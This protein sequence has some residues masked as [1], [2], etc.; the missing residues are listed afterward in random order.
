MYRTEM[1]VIR[2]LDIISYKRQSKYICK[3]ELSLSC[4]RA[5]QLLIGILVGEDVAVLREAESWRRWVLGLR[6]PL[7]ELYDISKPANSPTFS[8][9]LIFWSHI[10]NITS[11]PRA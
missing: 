1:V 10:K 2:L 11:E 5:N 9:W 3:Y 6:D 4:S 8:R 7:V